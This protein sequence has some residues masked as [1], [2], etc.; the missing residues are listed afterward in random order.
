MGDGEDAARGV[1]VG[2]IGQQIGADLQRRQGEE[3]GQPPPLGRVE[4]GGRRQHLFE[5]QAGGQRLGDQV[6]AFEQGAVAFTSP[7]PPNI[8]DPLVLT[9]GDHEHGS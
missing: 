8:L 9:T 7:E 2:Q 4:E 1:G 6:G 5:A 3:A